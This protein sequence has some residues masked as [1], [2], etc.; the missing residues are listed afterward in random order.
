[1]LVDGLT[2]ALTRQRFEHFRSLLR[3]ADIYERIQA[4]DNF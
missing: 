3:L 1:M 4:V 2:K